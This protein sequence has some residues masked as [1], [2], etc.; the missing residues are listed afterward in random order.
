MA[1][2]L[3]RTSIQEMLCSNSEVAV[4]RPGHLNCAGTPDSQSRIHM[5][6][7]SR[8]AKYTTEGDA[9]DAEIQP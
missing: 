1:V 6:I 5:E 4:S 3:R 9:G 8:K 7:C 2:F